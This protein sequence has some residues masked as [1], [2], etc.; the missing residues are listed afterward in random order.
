MEL[1][2]ETRALKE[3]LLEQVEEI[4]ARQNRVEPVNLMETF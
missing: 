3:K 2:Q 1:N 4:I